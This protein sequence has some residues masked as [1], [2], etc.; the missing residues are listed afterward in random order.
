MKLDTVVLLVATALAATLLLS[1]L[2]IALR[3]AGRVGVVRWLETFEPAR[4]RAGFVALVALAAGAGF[5]I[6]DAVSARVG[7]V[8]T[9]LGAVVPMLQGELTRASVYAPGNVV[10][11]MG[12]KGIVGPGV[13]ASD[14]SSL[15]V[16]SPGAPVVL[17]DAPHSAYREDATA[18]PAAHVDARPEVPALMETADVP[19]SPLTER[20][21]DAAGGEHPG[22]VDSAL[23]QP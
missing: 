6:S 2:G 14:P 20:Q 7:L 18:L 12:S 17:P 21:Q 3:R 23:H 5:T 10:I 22:E 15:Q 13:P 19:S 4:L 9:V 8:L 11:A 16:W 1:L